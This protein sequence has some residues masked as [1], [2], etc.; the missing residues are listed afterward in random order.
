M[1]IYRL[2]GQKLDYISKIFCLNYLSYLNLQN[3]ILIHQDFYTASLLGA[4]LEEADVRG[5]IL[6]GKDLT[7]LN[8]DTDSSTV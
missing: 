3:C 6:K 8:T 4:N 5:T 2:R 7:N 1:W